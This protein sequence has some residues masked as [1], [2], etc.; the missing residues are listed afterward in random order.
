M[1][2]FIFILAVAGLLYEVLIFP[3]MLL[4]CLAVYR[5]ARAICIQWHFTGSVNVFFDKKIDRLYYFS[6]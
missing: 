4:L 3:V 2:L 5:D 1:M 6:R